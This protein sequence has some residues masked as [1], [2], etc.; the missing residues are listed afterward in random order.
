MAEGEDLHSPQHLRIH[1]LHYLILYHWAHLDLVPL[2]MLPLDYKR[3]GTHDMNSD[4][5]S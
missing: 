3:E 2:Y 4:L 1:V 5:S